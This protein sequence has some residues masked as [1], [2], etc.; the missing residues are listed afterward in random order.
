MFD[1][2]LVLDT[3]WILAHDFG[4]YGVQRDLKE[5]GYRPGLSARN[6]EVEN[7]PLYLSLEHR[8][9]LTGQWDRKLARRITL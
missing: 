6:G 7:W 4:L 1:R 3:V 9:N 5:R 2:I 8:A